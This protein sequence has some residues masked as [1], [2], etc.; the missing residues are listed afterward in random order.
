MIVRNNNNSFMNDEFG[1]SNINNNVN[2]TYQGNFNNYTFDENNQKSIDLLN[3]MKNMLNKIDS[4][5]Y[6][7]NFDLNEY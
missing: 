5:I 1:N 7:E 3:N 4:E 2:L 6:G